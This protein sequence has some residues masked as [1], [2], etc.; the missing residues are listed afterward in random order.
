M[1]K[2]SENTR[3]HHLEDEQFIRFCCVFVYWHDN[4]I[5]AVF[6]RRFQR[7]VMFPESCQMPL[8]SDLCVIFTTG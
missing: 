6:H 1:E 5:R 4:Y 8:G 3:K 2:I 7:A